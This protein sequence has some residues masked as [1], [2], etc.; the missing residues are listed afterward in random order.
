[1][2]QRTLTIYQNLILDQSE[3]EEWLKGV[4]FFYAKTVILD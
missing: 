1:V 4:P 2:I 3:S